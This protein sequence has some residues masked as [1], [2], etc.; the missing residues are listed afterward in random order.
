MASVSDRSTAV[1]ERTFEEHRPRHR[2]RLDLSRTWAAAAI[3][4]P[5]IVISLLPLQAIDLA[6]QLRAGASMLATWSLPRV[7]T[8]TLLAAGRPW[9][10][11]QWAAQIVL[12]LG[13]RG[14]GW[15]G[16]A[17]LRTALVGASASLVY[18]AC[19]DAGAERMPA[20][21]LTL[22]GAAF[23]IG[24]SM[25][26]P[27]LLGM[28]CFGLVLWAVVSRLEHPARF[29][30]VVPVT[31]LW[32]NL[33]GTFFLAP[34]T[35][36]L[37][38]VRD[39]AE[40]RPTRRSWWMAAATLAATLVNPFGPRV[41][42]YVVDL[43]TNPLIRSFIQEWRSPTLDPRGGMI[44]EITVL[45][46]VTFVGAVFLVARSSHRPRWP[47][48]LAL[49]VYVAPGLTS[50]RGIFWWGMA[51]PTIVSAVVSE[52]IPKPRRDPTNAFN[53]SVVAA[54]G[55]ALAITLVRFPP[56]RDAAPPTSLVSF[57]PIEVTQKLGEILRPGEPVFNAQ[58]WGSWLEYALPDHPVVADSRIEVIPDRVWSDY[59]AVSAGSD[60]WEETLAGWG[61][62]VVAVRFDQQ[63]G[64]VRAMRASADWS[65]VLTTD[66]G[67][68]FVRRDG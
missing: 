57:A 22:L 28:A 55:L 24:G 7:D 64:L 43:S 17:A 65:E 40:R 34:A 61:I 1:A 50:I 60:G 26:R 53:T 68:V 18:L 49:V 44:F 5:T 62:R 4:V 35:V 38:A 45:Y 14:G 67:A 11:Q 52:R 12:D 31:V 41:W 9:V 56:Y 48:L 66:D 59:L 27:Q 8:Y 20:A 47:L 46:L 25:L 54:L 33:H 23:F 58:L 36:A 10:D 32:A 15:F 39:A 63:H 51:A 3:L 16:L 21:A 29:L 37:A 2:G 19:R 42:A 13:F 6:Y 30:L